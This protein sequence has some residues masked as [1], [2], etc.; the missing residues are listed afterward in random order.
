MC[1]GAASCRDN[2][3]DLEILFIELLQQLLA[4]THIPERPNRI[5]SAAID[6]SLNAPYVNGG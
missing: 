1:A 2:V 4:T 6:V 5:G 3:I